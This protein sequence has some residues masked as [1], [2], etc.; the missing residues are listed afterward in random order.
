MLGVHSGFYAYTIGQRQGL[1]VG[2]IKPLY[3]CQIRPEKN[4]IVVGPREALFTTTLTAE[5]FNWIGPLPEEKRLRVQAQIRHRHEP[6]DG[7][8]TITSPSP[9]PIL[10][11]LNL[12]NR[13]GL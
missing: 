7:T 12:I 4:E 6:A 1:G 5:D 9:R 13:N 11:I 2:A 3:V 8:L 10:S